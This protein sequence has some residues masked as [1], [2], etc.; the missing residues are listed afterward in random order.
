M[1]P[2]Q[3]TR[4]TAAL[5]LTGG[6]LRTLPTLGFLLALPNPNPV[7]G[8]PGAALGNGLEGFKVNALGAPSFFLPVGLEVGGT[9]LLAGD[10]WSGVTFIQ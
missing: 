4:L 3:S 7:P 6:R 1:R 9:G 8:L 2:L 5:R 10:A